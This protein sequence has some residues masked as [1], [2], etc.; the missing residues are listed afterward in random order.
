[1]DQPSGSGYGFGDSIGLLQGF[2]RHHA[3]PGTTIYTDEAR[4]YR[5]M[6]GFDR[7]NARF[8][9]NIDSMV[10]MVAGMV[11]KRLLYKVLVA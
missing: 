1:M 6:T 4:A 8:L 9:D 10:S 7:H 11:G 5:G 3:V 2:V